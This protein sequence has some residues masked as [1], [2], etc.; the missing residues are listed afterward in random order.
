M[1]R[2]KILHIFIEPFIYTFFISVDPHDMS[3]S[4]YRQTHYSTLLIIITLEQRNGHNF[5]SVLCSFLLTLMTFIYKNKEMAITSSGLIF[6]P[7]TLLEL[8]WCCL[9]V[10]VISHNFSGHNFLNYGLI[11]NL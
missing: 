7:L 3:S 11:F 8:P 2:N 5:L 6:N 4:S 10:C 9:F 1:I